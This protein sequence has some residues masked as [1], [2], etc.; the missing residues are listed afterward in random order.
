MEL[1]QSIRLF[2][3]LA[4]LQSFT[5]AADALQIGRPQVTLAINQLE[6]SLGVRL[7]QRTTRRV[8]LTAE[9]EAFLAKAEEILG[10]VDEAVTMFS[11][12]SH[13]VRGRL[14]IDVPSAFAVESFMAMIGRFKQA[15]PGVSMTLGVS[16]RSV[17]LIA[18]GVDCVLRIGELP[19][20]TLVARRL[21]ALEMIT[22]ASPGYVQAAPALE[23]PSDLADQ[24]CVNFLSGLS[25]RA[26]PWHF[27]IQGQDAVIAP[28]STMLVS[29]ASAYV[30][31]ARAGFGV[32]QVPG[33]LVDRYLRDGSLVEVLGSFR[34]A[35]RPV[36][37]V[38][39]SRAHLAPPLKAFAEWVSEH[40]ATLDPRWL[41]ANR[42]SER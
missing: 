42:G 37:L 13:T 26:L 30:Q 18:E 21:G 3:K 33:L 25:R 36:S 11:A 8:S 32:I 38:Y 27:R 14:R 24:A 16:D 4:E 10:G 6:A 34:P 1:L 31:C 28:R 19:S 2:S 23:L 17:D 29:D 5:K 40:V 35:A 41:G 15:Y 20:S 39:P 22:C 12:P 7:F 9:G